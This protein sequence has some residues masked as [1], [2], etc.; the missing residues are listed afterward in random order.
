MVLFYFLLILSILSG[1]QL[2][3]ESCQEG[4]AEAKKDIENENFKLISY[5]LV[6][7][8]DIK[9]RAFQIDY[10]AKKY[11]V[12]LGDGGCVISDKII[13]Y[14]EAMEVAIL[15]KFGSD[16]FERIESEAREAYE[17]QSE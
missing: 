8:K 15:K 14:S 5:G 12:V 1:S 3:K 6:I 16:F 2:D 10:I 13:C 4:L 7:H 11:G 17:S 9:F